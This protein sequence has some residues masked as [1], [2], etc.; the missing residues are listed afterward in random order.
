MNVCQWLWRAAAAHP[1][2]PA[3]LWG[4]RLYTRYAE[5]ARRADALGAALQRRFGVG[6]GDRVG[7]FMTNH[8]AYLEILFGAWSIGAAV[9]PINAKLHPREADWIIADAACRLVFTSGVASVGA[10]SRPRSSPALP[11]EGALLDLVDVDTPTYAEL[12]RGDAPPAPLATLPDHLAWLFYTSGTTGRPKGV[13]ITHGNLAAMVA[14]FFIDVDRALP[15]DAAFYAAPMSHGAGL[16]A[17]PYILKGARH[18]V[19]ES[20]GFDPGETLELAERARD[21]CMFLAPTMVRRLTAAAKSAGGRGDGIRTIV[22]GGGPMYL[23]DIAEAVDLMGDRFVQI[24]GQGESPMTITALP[25]EAHLDRRSAG[26][27]QRLASVGRAQALVD[28]R[29]A[30]PDG[31]PAA[32]G[33]IGEVVVRGPT[34]MAGYWQRPE[35]TAE[36]LR[37]G[38]LW[39]GDLG[40]MDDAGYLTLRDRS[41]DMIISGGTNI[42]PREIEE[43]LI[44]HEAVSE[45][46]V[47]GRPHEEWG[48]EVVAFVVLEPGQACTAEELD[49]L[50]LGRI[51]RFKRPR[52]YVFVEALPKNNYGKVL[53]TELRT[54][55]PPGS[56]DA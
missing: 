25:R 21:L 50:C 4:D 33:E 30:R 51:A 34:V 39:T 20:R 35:A 46:A 23:A 36:T 52:H 6:P 32:A 37:D 8:P 22:Y 16:Y 49:R 45:A 38:W 26:W 43:V 48:E 24:Y 27:R 15:G 44:A 56:G 42:Y 2:R 1:D 18:I 12:L 13:M 3:V 31:T 11:A 29:I 53:K 7:I 40:E 55:R 5:L 47:V 10:A 28:V 9:V 54:S 17:L 14:S 41:K 19:P